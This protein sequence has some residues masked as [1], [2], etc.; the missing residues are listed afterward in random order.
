MIDREFRYANDLE[1]YLETYQP[2][3]PFKDKPDPV[4]WR[5]AEKLLEIAANTQPDEKFLE[6]L[7]IQI[8]EAVRSPVEII[9]QTDYRALN[10]QSQRSSGRIP[11]FSPSKKRQLLWLPLA[12]SMT[13]V[14]LFVILAASF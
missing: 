3:Q 13:L 2:D 9:V 1:V 8:E 14:L 5:L 10:I 12:A 6:Y 7:E 4:E 11:L